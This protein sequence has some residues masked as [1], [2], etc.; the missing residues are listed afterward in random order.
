MRDDVAI[1]GIITSL[2]R[3]LVYRGAG[4]PLYPLKNTAGAIA[5]SSLDDT[6]GNVNIVH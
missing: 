4:Q 6:H 2:E 3:G 5:C 1:P